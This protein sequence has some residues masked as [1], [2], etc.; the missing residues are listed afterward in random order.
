VVAGGSYSLVK[1]GNDAHMSYWPRSHA[2]DRNGLD[3]GY[4]TTKAENWFQR[5]LVS[6]EA[7]NYT[8]VKNASNWR[9]ALKYSAK[10]SQD[11]VR[12]NERRADEA[13]QERDHNDV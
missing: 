5:H 7:G 8:V 1:D 3:V 11:L 13:L 4:W 2:W 6:L 9:R 10:K 12:A